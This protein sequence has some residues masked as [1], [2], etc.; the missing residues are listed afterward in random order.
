MGRTR[1]VTRREF[2]KQSA[3]AAT[4]VLVPEVAHNAKVTPINAKRA[5]VSLDGIWRFMPAVAEG[6]T[7]KAGWGQIRVPGSWATRRGRAGGTTSDLL[8][9]GTGPQWQLYDGGRLAA[10]WYERRVRIPA[11]WQGRVVTLR[12]DRVSTDAIVYVNGKESGRVPWPWGS[13][14]ITQAVRPGK[15]ADIQVLVAA[16]ADSGLVGHFWQN[17]FMAVT[18]TPANLATRGLTGSVYL[19]SRSSEAHVS[20]VFIRTSTRKSEITLDVDLIGVKRAGQVH[21]VADMLNQEGKAEKSVASDAVVEAKQMQTVTVSWPWADPRLWD[22]GQPNLYTLR[23]TVSGAGVDDQYSQEFG[24]R[25]FWIEG[26]QFYLNGTVTHLRQANFN[27][28]PLGQ[29][30]DNF[31]EFGSWTPDARGSDSDAGPELSRADHK[32]YLGA[33]FIL[34]ANKYIINSKREFIWEKDKHHAWERAAVW[35]R[36]HRNH[37]SVVMWV[38]GTNFF[39]NAVDLDPRHIGRRGWGLSD[40]RW[41]RLVHIAGELFAGLKRL[42]P[43][44]VYYSHEG[45]YTGD[46]HS[47]NCYLDLLPL[48]EREDWLSAWA[49]S[50]DMPIT[51]T[52][53]GT[54]TGCTFRRGHDGFGSNIHSEPLLTEYV[55]IY[56][57][58]DA[59]GSEGSKYRQ[60]IQSQFLGGMEYKSS[61]DQLAQFPDMRKIQTLFRK[62]TWRSWRTAGL[63]GGLK[64]WSW[65]EVEL[66]EVNGP[67]LAWIAGPPGD[68]TAKDHHFNS[69]QQFE[70]QI[71]LI[72]DQRHPQDFEVSWTA[73]VDRKEAS[74]G[75][76]HGSLGI[77][78]IRKI[79]IEITAPQVEAGRQADGLI[80]LTATIGKSNHQDTFGFRVFR[81]RQRASREMAVFDPEGMTSRMLASL[82][83]ATLA[84]HHEPPG[85]V[86]IGRNGLKHDPSVASRLEPYVRNG[87]R[88]LIFAQ[89]PQ[90]MTKAFGWRVCPKVARRVF[91]VSSSVVEEID[92][93]DLRDWTGS[94]TLIPAYPKYAGDYLRGNEGGQP[95]AGWH[96]GNRGGVSSAAI[97][98]PHRSGQR[99]LLEC[100]FDLAYT[101]LMELDYGQGRVIFCTLDLEDHVALDPAASRM[102]SHIVDYALHCPLAPRLNKVAYLGG[103]SGATWLDSI[104]VSYQQSPTLDEEAGLLLIAPDAT[105]DTAALIA[106][107]HKGGKAFFLPRS[108]AQG[109]LGTTLKPAPAHFAGSLSVP[110]WPEANGLSASDL[111]W[112]TY[113]DRPPWIL[114][115]GTDIGADGLIGRRLTGEGVAIFC[116]VDPHCLHADVK[117]YFHCTRWRSTRAVAQILA[118]LGASFPVDGRIFQP[119]DVWS[120]NLNGTWQMKITLKLAPA[121]G[122]ATAHP[123][124]GITPAAQALV[125]RSVS[126]AGWTAIT[127]PQMVPFF[128][129]RDGEAVLRKEIIVPADVAGR[130]LIL[131]LGV[132]DGVDSA[133]FNGMEI[134]QTDTGTDGSQAPG[135]YVVPGKLIKAGRNAIAVRLFD[136]FGPGGFLGKPG[137]PVAPGGDRSGHQCTGPRIGLEMSLGIKPEGAQTLGYYCPDY[138]TDFPMGDNPYRYYRW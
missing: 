37:P 93:D 134:G 122:E 11:E 4:G 113:L 56:F 88:A 126:A 79:P 2:V 6:G 57:G 17:A 84:W 101:P 55:A 63:P 110:A 83:C 58:A 10:A 72:N 77:S 25:E 118:N 133:Y 99:P 117:T 39:N 36:H 138:L 22:V 107:L 53:F 92:A 68:Y 80:E 127:L 23:L 94:S 46:V 103:A 45:A 67:T 65:L 47:M 85:L 104:G 71:V 19:E 26:R 33:V 137:L 96:W 61:Q 15:T 60:W 30:G 119:L 20:D 75:E 1:N 108:Q 74:K 43:T 130:D 54:P 14:D 44:R 81:K 98:K 97:E 82:G 111:R 135:N 13:V 114:N 51:M 105:L 125:R 7:P 16:L 27:H 120:V 40:E 48:Q 123:D 124:P 90:W 112:R 100:E 109:W 76:F 102:A 59:Y 70:K 91:P 115:T 129:D 62:N 132:V 18:Y 52:E 5:Q 89:D 87:G 69:G 86:V 106:Y 12:F 121:A 28:G 32:G 66:K 73:M 3:F 116:Q 64:T 21:F 128:N 24:F 49:K 78:E 29:V 38:A 9:R 136:R 131:E 8:G 35:M 50:G 34:D 41:N 95:Y 31:S 42:D